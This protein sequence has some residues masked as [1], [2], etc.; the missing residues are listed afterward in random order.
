MYILYATITPVSCIHT[1]LCNTTVQQRINSKN[2]KIGQL[3]IHLKCCQS[4]S[5]GKCS[6]LNRF[7]FTM[8]RS[9]CHHWSM[10]SSITDCFKPEDTTT[11][12]CSRSS[13]HVSSASDMP[14][15][16]WHNKLCSL[17]D[18]NPDC[19]GARVQV[20]WTVMFHEPEKLRCHENDA[21]LRCHA[22][23]QTGSNRFN[24]SLSP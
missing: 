18:L 11:K 4:Y 2:V 22:A 7:A 5:Y 24:N 3:V 19:F 10:A 15:L 12:R 16:A 14:S 9:R 8:A 13:Y 23:T 1:L 17:L 6:K 20:L 21:Q